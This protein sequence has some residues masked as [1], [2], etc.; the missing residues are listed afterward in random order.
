MSFAAF[1]PNSFTVKAGDSVKLVLTSTD[2]FHTFTVTELG[3]D[4]VV[5]AIG[6]ETREVN[7]PNQPGTYKVFCRPHEIYGMTGMITVTP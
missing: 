6:T 7:I 1:S 3:I 4:I 5:A 2:G